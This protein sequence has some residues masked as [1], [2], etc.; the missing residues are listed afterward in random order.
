MI[1]D[2]GERTVFETGFQRDMHAGKGRFDLLPWHAIWEVAKHC[3]EGALKYGERNIDKGAPQHSL[4]DSAFRH[5]AKYTM[6][7]TDED[8]LRAAAWNIL[9]ALEQ[10]AKGRTDLMDIPDIPVLEGEGYYTWFD[11]PNGEEIKL[12]VTEYDKSEIAE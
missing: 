4:I 2:S 6:G 3:E 1:K 8:H 11:M 12:K 10:K 7:M 5:M 9:W